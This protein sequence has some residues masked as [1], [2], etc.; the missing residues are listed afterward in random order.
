MASRVA[1]APSFGKEAEVSLIDYIKEEG[2]RLGFDQVAIARAEKYQ[3]HEALQRWLADGFH[4]SMDWME[5]QEDKRRD[6]QAVMRGAQSIITCALNYNTEHPYSTECADPNRG[7][8]ARYAWGDDY[9]D[10]MKKMLLELVAAIQKKVP[11]A[12]CRSYVDTGPV[13]ERVFAKHSGIG[14]IGKNTCII[15]KKLGSFLFLGGILTDL[16][17]EPDSMVPDYCGSCTACIDACP[18][19][20]IVESHKLD[21]RRCISYLTIEHRGDIDSELLGKMGNHLFGCDIC[22]DVCPWNR[23][24]PRTTRPEFQPR[25]GF[26]NPDL[27]QFAKR[28]KEKYPHGFKNSPLKRAKKEGL[29]RNARQTLP[30]KQTG[31]VN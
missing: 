4:G 6:P 5:R 8:I 20:A 13:M 14:W 31:C 7:W 28:V 2:R 24:S 29:L 22:Q 27:T 21:A 15:N 1:N 30:C 3:E 19:Q 16:K 18:T 12:L 11:Q 25:D 26:F 23:K 9:H 10:L 17:L